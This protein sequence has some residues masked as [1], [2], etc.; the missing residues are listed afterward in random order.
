[1]VGSHNSK[2]NTNNSTTNSAVLQKTQ[3]LPEWYLALRAKTFLSLNLPPREH[4]LFP[5]SC[6]IYYNLYRR[7]HTCNF[8]MSCWCRG[9]SARQGVRETREISLIHSFHLQ[10]LRWMPRQWCESWRLCVLVNLVIWRVA[11]L[12]FRVPSRSHFNLF[13][14]LSHFPGKHALLNI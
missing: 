1:M 12:W 5:L 3:G 4:I 7:L 2:I 11:A 9:R 14:V 13:Y 10:I 8:N 6:S